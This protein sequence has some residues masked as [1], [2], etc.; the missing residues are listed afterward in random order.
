MAVT[1]TLTSSINIW[2]LYKNNTKAYRDAILSTII[3][4][5]SASLVNLPADAISNFACR[6]GGTA[7]SGRRRL[8]ANDHQLIITYT[9]TANIYGVTYP[10]LSSALV[11]STTGPAFVKTLHYYAGKYGVAGLFSVTSVKT[12][13]VDKNK[14]SKSNSF[15]EVFGIN[16]GY[17]SFIGI[18]AGL[19]IIAA[20]SL[21]KYRSSISNPAQGSSHH[22][23]EPPSFA[24][25]S[26]NGLEETRQVAN[27]KRRSRIRKVV[28]TPILHFSRIDMVVTF[29]LV[30]VTAA[31]NFMQ[32]HYDLVSGGALTANGVCILFF[33]LINAMVSLYI[34]YACY[35]Q[36]WLREHFQAELLVKQEHK[37]LWTS[38]CALATLDPTLVRFLPWKESEFSQASQ[39]FPN[40]SLYAITNALTLFNLLL[41]TGLSSSSLAN[42]YQAIQTFDL[43]F[44]FSLFS[45]LFH[46]ANVVYRMLIKKIQNINVVVEFGLELSHIPPTSLNS[47]EQAFPAA[48]TAIID[49]VTFG[50]DG[51]LLDAVS[52]SLD[53]IGGAAGAKR[54]RKTAAATINAP[55][56]LLRRLDNFYEPV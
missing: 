52:T 4:S 36:S 21:W 40:F 1:Q 47:N 43:S 35:K 8:Q 38:I 30:L 56:P 18:I 9:I 29:F 27:T 34:V 45:L 44:S 2:D 23:S 33:R 6:E 53:E 42:P 28:S 10:L 32:A 15:G 17:T 19:S 54:E 13:T 37:Y 50:E 39:G 24:N 26:T 55:S 12:K 5:I 3:F 31:A 22:L 16:A 46:A 25:A 11:S 7:A 49:T 48:S 51:S 14:R 20:L 41:V